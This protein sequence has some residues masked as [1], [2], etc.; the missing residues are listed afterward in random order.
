VLLLYAA[1]AQGQP[2]IRSLT[3][4]IDG[5]SVGGVTIDLVGNLYVA[6]FGDYVW[7]ITPAVARVTSFRTAVVR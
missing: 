3:S 4:V 7:K 5:H 1:S 6:D 2:A